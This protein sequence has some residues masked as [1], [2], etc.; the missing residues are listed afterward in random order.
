MMPEWISV[1]EHLPRKNGKYLCCC[2]NKY[3]RILGFAKSLYSVDSYTFANEHRSGF[4][5]YDHEYGYFEYDSI[6]HWMPLPEP[7]KE[8]ADNG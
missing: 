8:G 3:I 7:P 2:D 1:E 4:Y 5:D 6:T